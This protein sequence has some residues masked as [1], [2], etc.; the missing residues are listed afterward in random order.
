M[1][2]KWKLSIP[3]VAVAAALVIVTAS[4]ASTARQHS[5]TALLRVATTAGV[6]TWDPIKSFSTEVL[7]MANIYEPLV[8]ANPP[9]SSKP[10]RPGLATNWGR[11]KDGKTWTFTPPPGREVPQRRAPDVAGGQGLARRREE[12]GRRLVHL[13]ARRLD[14]DAERLHR[15]LQSLL[16]VPDDARRGLRERRLDRL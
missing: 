8:Y 14:H 11:S 9:G 13:G 10:F 6:T 16:L 12:A 15:R 4:L 3:L 2:S 1:R 7:Y 5:S